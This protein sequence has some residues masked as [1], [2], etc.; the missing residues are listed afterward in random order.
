M[1]SKQALL[2]SESKLS[3]DQI[4][5]Q[6]LERKEATYINQIDSLKSEKNGLREDLLALEGRKNELA[7]KTG[8]LDLLKD[9]ITNL[10]TRVKKERDD[11]ERAEREVFNLGRRMEDKQREEEEWKRKAKKMEEEVI[12]IEKERNELQKVIL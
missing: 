8:D 6:D 4:L 2:L 11:K 10:E 5:I 12:D 9:R 1:Q 3:E 7:R